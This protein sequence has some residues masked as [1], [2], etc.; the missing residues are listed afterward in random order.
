MKT[1]RVCSGRSCRERGA[2]HLMEALA[3]HYHTKPGGKHAEVDLNFC[4]C[5]GYCDN[6]PNVLIDDTILVSDAKTVNI[7]E[8]VE[9]KQGRDIRKMS[10]D[11]LTKDDFLGDVF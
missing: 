2:T 10:L 5:I 9:H 4:E 1:I 7:V 3:E 11:E 8:Q 6:A